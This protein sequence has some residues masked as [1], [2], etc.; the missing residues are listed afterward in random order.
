[1]RTSQIIGAFTLIADLPPVKTDGTADLRG[2]PIL[3]RLKRVL[4]LIEENQ[5]PHPLSQS[6]SPAGDSAGS[7]VEAEGKLFMPSLQQE[8]GLAV[9]RGGRAQT[10]ITNCAVLLRT[11]V[12]TNARIHDLIDDKFV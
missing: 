11:S 2:R 12:S 1:M 7:T 3:R 10:H 6:V 9:K 8:A 5:Q 4:M